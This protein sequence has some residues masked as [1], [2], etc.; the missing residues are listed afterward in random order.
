MKATIESNN[1]GSGYKVKNLIEYLTVM[2]TPIMDQIKTLGSSPDKK[3]SPKG[4]YTTTVILDN[5]WS[6]SW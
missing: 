2:I 1:Q 3:N 4:Q 5:S 6:P